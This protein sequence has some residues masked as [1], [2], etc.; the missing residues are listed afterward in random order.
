MCGLT[1][2]LLARLAVTFLV[3]AGLVQS[4]GCNVAQSHTPPGGSPGGA[5]AQGANVIYYTEQATHKIMQC[6]L[7]GSNPRMVLDTGVEVQDLKVDSIGGRM[8]WIGGGAIYSANLDGTDAEM[9]VSNLVDPSRITLDPANNRLFVTRCWEGLILTAPMSGGVATTV[10]KIDGNPDGITYD[11]GRLYW[12]DWHYL[13]SYIASAN[14][15]GTGFRTLTNVL[16]KH[17]VGA[18]T[19]SGGWVYFG[20]SDQATATDANAVYKVRTD[21]TGLTLL[22][23][24]TNPSGMAVAGDTLYWASHNIPL[25]EEVGG[26][27]Q[28]VSIEGGV[29][30][31]LLAD[32]VRPWGIAIVDSGQIPSR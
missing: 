2:G 12:A 19:S 16:Q 5:F 7:D 29:P 28:C 20:G 9:V 10:M 21:G 32:A 14:A 31:T 1:S 3:A 8:Y 11:N 15:D 13:H 18:I 26:S 4:Y 25:G 30:R 24:T 6:S 23:H 27:I 17:I 22:A